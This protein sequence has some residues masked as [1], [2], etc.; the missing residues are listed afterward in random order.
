MRQTVASIKDQTI[1]VRVNTGTAQAAVQSVR[2]K[3]A[4]IR[5]KVVNVRVNTTG[6]EAN[7][8]GVSNSLTEFATKAGLAAIAVTALQSALS[9]GKSAFV[10]YNAELEQTHVDAR[11]CGPGEYYDRKPAEICSGNAI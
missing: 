6:A 5:D 2:D 9:A 10:D 11:L 1:N 4:G 3:I 7:V 8:A